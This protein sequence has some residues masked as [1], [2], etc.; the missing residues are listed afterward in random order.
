MN[1]YVQ[2]LQVGVM[3]KPIVTRPVFPLTSQCCWVEPVACSD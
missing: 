3:T 1:N 2:T